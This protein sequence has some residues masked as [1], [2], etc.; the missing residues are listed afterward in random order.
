MTEEQQWLE[1]EWHAMRRRLVN[2]IGENL[3]D[4]TEGVTTIPVKAYTCRRRFAAERERLFRRAPLLAGFSQ[5]VAQPGQ[6]MLLDG[7]GP[8]VFIMR[9]EDG[10]LGAWLNVCPHRGAR[11]VH[12]EG[13]RQNIVCPF[14]AW[15][16]DAGGALTRRPMDPCFAGADVALTAVPVAEKYGMVFVRVTPGGA[17]IDVDEFL[18]PMVPLLKAFRLDQAMPVGKDSYRVA[19]NWKIAL[20]TGCEGYHVAA[21]HAK[22]LSPQLMPF[23]TIHDSFGR[24]HRYSQGP[25]S[26]MRCVG[27]PED[28]WPESHYGAAHYLFPNIVFS[29]TEA[30]DGSVPVLALLRLF[31]GRHIG[32]TLVVHNLYKPADAADVDDAAFKALHRAIIDINQTEDLTVA[33]DVWDNY[34]NLGDDATMILGRN[35]MILQRYHRDIAEFIDMPW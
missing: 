5:E 1:R 32:E 15:R 8:G 35:E 31:P 30:I 11:L 26:L 24:H 34:D 10:S 3:S 33:A 16:F 21:T 6:I 28:Q 4:M 23:T 17:P 22:T 9:R 18:G 2:R 12:E 7:A 29:Y 19:T 27:V 14:H 13:I 25:R 20:D